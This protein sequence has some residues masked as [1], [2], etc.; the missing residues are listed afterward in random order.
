M[1]YDI[2]LLQIH[3]RD[4]RHIYKMPGVKN[5]RKKSKL[6]EKKVINY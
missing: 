3:T 2:F 1:Q 6:K 5:S 4:K